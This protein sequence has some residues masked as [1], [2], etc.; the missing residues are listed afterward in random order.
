MY[1]SEFVVQ[2]HNKLEQDF[3]STT[4]VDKYLKQFS[5]SINE[6][7]IIIWMEA[8][9]LEAK[10]P[11]LF[12]Q[13]DEDTKRMTESYCRERYE[14][15]SS[16]HL[17]A[18]YSWDLWWFTEEREYVFL[19]YAQEH[20]K[21]LLRFYTTAKDYKEARVFCEYFTRLYP[22][23][24]RDRSVNELLQI[25]YDVLNGGNN[26][27]KYWL[28]SEI[29]SQEQRDELRRDKVEGYK[30]QAPLNL[31][32]RFDRGKLAK[33]CVDLAK[34]ELQDNKHYRLVTMAVR[35]AEKTNDHFIK[36]E[37]FE[38]LGDYEMAHLFSDDKYNIAVA[39]Q[40]DCK[41]RDIM[42]YYKMAGKEDKLL[43]A[44]L[45]YERNQ[46]NLVFLPFC[47]TIS[48]EEEKRQTEQLKIVLD[49]IL[50][51]GFNS[52]MSIL[53]GYNLDVF[54]SYKVLKE[55]AV[56]SASK[57][58]YTLNLGAQ[59][60]DTNMNT[61]DTTHE[62]MIMQQ[63]ADY[64]YRNITYPVFAGMLE[65]GRKK[66]IFSYSKLKKTLLQ[67]GFDLRIE[68]NDGLGYKVGTSYLERVELGLKDFIRLHRLFMEQKEV[69]WRYCITFLS[70][71]FEGLLR[72][73]IKRLGDITVRI[74]D[75]K[76]IELIP[77]EGLFA[78]KK[79][80][81]VF[82][83]EDMLLFQE[84]FT[85][86]GYNIRNDVAHGIM[87]PQEYSAMKAM[88]VFVSIIRLSKATS[89]LRNMA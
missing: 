74:K 88:L 50:V 5:T 60:K 30:D 80:R 67:L 72:N 73:I 83:D 12:R 84:T 59:R 22:Y 43:E 11:W 29:D 63:M 31:L 76:S 58:Y 1:K 64:T 32:K 61:K 7:Q 87:I 16:I 52:I 8:R 23:C 25:A 34:M 28:I 9:L 36:K 20:T 44:T 10:G 78:S 42:W 69:D 57:Y 35:Y 19:G 18:K 54:L 55:K 75:D 56:K 13:W 24:C 21:H 71:Q 65:Q 51:N 39:Q 53:L 77:L 62:K 17:R 81:L 14:Q 85:K 41:L 37:A 47:S 4:N 89:L 15:T 27:L 48:S 2:L 45:K 6:E 68:K 33:A 46:D 79:L 38:M 70:T 3:L 40:N 49:S 66:K 86:D 82:N 26:I